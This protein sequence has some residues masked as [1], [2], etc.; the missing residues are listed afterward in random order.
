MRILI[1]ILLFF[2]AIIA[3]AQ[4]KADSM[5][6]RFVFSEKTLMDSTDFILD[7]IYKNLNK[8]EIEIY[9]YVEEGYLQDRFFNIN[10]EMERQKDIKF[11]RYPIR[12]YKNPLLAGVKDSLRHYDL[13]KKRLNSFSSDTLHLN[14]LSIANVFD[15]GY[16][17]FRANLRV[18]TILDK[19]PYTD[20]KLEKPPPEDKIEYITSKWFYFRITKNIRRRIGI[21]NHID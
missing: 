19:T 6:V 21:Q 12:Y 4:R 3:N 14:L 20:P 7:V 10:I 13:P 2:L 9:K 5:T 8:K 15:S 11:S 17:R 1:S 18:R 16:Y